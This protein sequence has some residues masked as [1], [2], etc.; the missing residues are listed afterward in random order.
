MRLNYFDDLARGNFKHNAAGRT[1]YFPL[2][3]FGKGRELTDA[4][5][6]QQLREGLV[7]QWFLLACCV[8]LVAC[9]LLLLLVGDTFDER[10]TGIA[11]I[12]LFG[13]AGAAKAYGLRQRTAR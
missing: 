1:V 4:A 13:A 7:T 10:V 5:T 12:V 2:S 9:G 3:V 8:A 11:V 6:E